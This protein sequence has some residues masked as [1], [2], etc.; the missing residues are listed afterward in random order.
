MEVFF[1][2]QLYFIFPKSGIHQKQKAP[3]VTTCQIYG[4]Q[5]VN[6]VK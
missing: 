4:G 2:S 6:Y 3:I 5:K 1:F